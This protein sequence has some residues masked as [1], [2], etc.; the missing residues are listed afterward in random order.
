MIKVFPDELR[1]LSRSARENLTEQKDFSFSDWETNPNA[2][3]PI[4]FRNINKSSEWLSNSKKH[5]LKTINELDDKY[6][7]YLYEDYNHWFNEYEAGGSVSENEKQ[8][9]GF[10]VF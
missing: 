10:Q 9:K 2:P 5:I 7:D 8:S 1:D 6:F 4:D 3:Q